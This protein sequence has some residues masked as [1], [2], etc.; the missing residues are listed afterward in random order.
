[1]DKHRLSIL[2][3]P[4][5]QACPCKRF[6]VNASQSVS[7]GKCKLRVK[8]IVDSTFQ[9][10]GHVVQPSRVMQLIEEIIIHGLMTSCHKTD[11]ALAHDV[12]V[13]YIQK[14]QSGTGVTS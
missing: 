1:M 9:D 2:K 7:F 14:L 5:Y 8:K 6:D 3:M 4:R 10:C 13:G 12:D 11:E